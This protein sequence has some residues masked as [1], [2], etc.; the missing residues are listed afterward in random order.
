[1]TPLE[2]T[3]Q[4]NTKLATWGDRMTDDIVALIE[5]GVMT[6]P[7]GSKKV[8]EIIK[9]QLRVIA[10]FMIRE[11]ALAGQQLQARMNEPA[12]NREALREDRP[13]VGV[14]AT[15]RRVV[16]DLRPAEH[17]TQRMPAVVDE[18]YPDDEVT[19]KMG[20]HQEPHG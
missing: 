3:R 20:R 18:P 8:P 2:L 5:R 9:A 11:A 1:M 7:Q 4:L 12:A 10:G 14:T 19:V 6:L 13:L 16:S 17:I 15:A